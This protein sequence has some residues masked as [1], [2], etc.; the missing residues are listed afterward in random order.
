MSSAP[1]LHSVYRLVTVG[2][3]DDI[4]ETA[5]NLARG[6][7]EDGTLVWAEPPETGAKP[8]DFA[9]AL[10]LRPECGRE[11]ALQLLYVAMLGLYEALGSLLPAAAPLVFEW[12]GTLVYDGGRVAEVRLETPA[13]TGSQEGD[14]DWVI[15]WASAHI[16]PR[17][18]DN[19][20]DSTSLSDEGCVDVGAGQVLERFARYF[21][22]WANRWQD[23]GF[24]PVRSTWL[25][26][27]ESVG[28]TVTV[29]FGGG[30]VTG[31][32][33]DVDEQGRLVLEADGEPRAVALDE[34]PFGAIG[35][36]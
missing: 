33:V 17:E 1:R 27:A 20:K 10:V 15:L 6:G 14:V 7:A 13:G 5:R 24:V 36:A 22:N 32:F 9:C 12:P 2:R 26:H 8:A 23:D 19:L 3:L 28:Q 31:T 29:P 11:S 35:P 4:R 34:T 25:W 16:A 30:D 21:L 18:R